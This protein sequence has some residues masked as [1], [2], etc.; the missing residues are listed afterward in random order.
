MKEALGLGPFE[1]LSR[2]FHGSKVLHASCQYEKFVL[3]CKFTEWEAS[4]EPW[5]VALVCFSP[6]YTENWG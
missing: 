2:F 6:S 3:K 1:P 5:G 4:D